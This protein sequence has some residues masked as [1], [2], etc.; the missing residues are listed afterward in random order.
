MHFLDIFPAV[1]TPCTPTNWTLHILEYCFRLFKIFKLS[2]SSAARIS[3]WSLCRWLWGFR[4]ANLLYSLL[5]HNLITLLQFDCPGSTTIIVPP[6]FL[7]HADLGILEIYFTSRS[8]LTISKWSIPSGV[9]VFKSWG[10]FSRGV[11]MFNAFFFFWWLC[12]KHQPT[13]KL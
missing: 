3:S 5:A 13:N 6:S 11:F 1:L 9:G 2:L 10:N 4:P 8:S 7:L 12:F